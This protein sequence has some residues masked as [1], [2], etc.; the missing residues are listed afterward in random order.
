MEEQYITKEGK[1]GKEIYVRDYNLGGYTAYFVDFPN[2][3]AEGETIEEAEINLWNT[4]YDVLKHL[5]K[6]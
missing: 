1:F 3:A 4:V 6:S 5:T 2:I